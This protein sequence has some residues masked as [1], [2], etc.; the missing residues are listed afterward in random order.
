MLPTALYSSETFLFFLQYSFL[1][2]AEQ[3]IGDV[4]ALRTCLQ[5]FG[6][7]HGLEIVMKYPP[8]LAIRRLGGNAWRRWRSL[9]VAVRRPDP[10]QTRPRD[11]KWTTHDCRR[12]SRSESNLQNKKGKIKKRGVKTSRLSSISDV[13]VQQRINLQDTRI[14]GKKGL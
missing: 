8:W 12:R 4:N 10:H 2:E 13:G 7:C 9:A 1:S 14:A 6:V 3:T 11:R 5:F